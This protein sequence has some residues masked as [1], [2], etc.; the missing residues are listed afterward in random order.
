MGTYHPHFLQ[1]D[2][3]QQ[4]VLLRSGWTKK[5]LWPVGLCHTDVSFPLGAHM[6]SKGQCIPTGN[7]SVKVSTKNKNSGGREKGEKPEGCNLVVLT[8][9][10]GGEL[11][12]RA[13]W[14]RFP[15]SLCW[16]HS[17]FGVT[18]D[19]SS[20]YLGNIT[21]QWVW[22]SDMPAET[23]LVCVILTS[24]SLREVKEGKTKYA[25]MS[26]QS[27]SWDSRRVFL[28]WAWSLSFCLTLS[29]NGAGID[30]IAACRQTYQ[31]NISKKKCSSAG[32]LF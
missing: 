8:Q 22:H 6:S 11:S 20:V 27:L 7:R 5:P 13:R 31:E 15:F 28:T 9:G 26:S 21:G 3:E 23:E 24:Y 25:G 2:G 30:A 29:H 1:L 10:A 14:I 19:R 12:A 16:H 4:Y 17:Y 18:M 32:V